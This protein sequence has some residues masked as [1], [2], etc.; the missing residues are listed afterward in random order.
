MHRAA[1]TQFWRASEGHSVEAAERRWWGFSALGFSLSTYCYF[2][3]GNH[4]PM[5]TRPKRFSLYWSHGKKAPRWWG[6]S[7]LVFSHST[8]CYFPS[9]IPGLCQ[10]AQSTWRYTEAVEIH[11]F[12]WR[13]FSAL[14][15]WYSICGTR[16]PGGTRRN[17]G[18]YVKLKKKYIYIVSW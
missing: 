3:S 7:A 1:Y 9:G 13:G 6:F 11:L 14:D 8:Y 18:G 10:P 17:L 4:W 16:T 2:P 5:S 15:R 12:G